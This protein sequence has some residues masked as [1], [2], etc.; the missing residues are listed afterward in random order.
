MLHV[1][2]S[3]R[4]LVRQTSYLDPF[5]QVPS[6]VVV[7]PDTEY[8]HFAISRHASVLAV[9]SFAPHISLLT[10]QFPA[11][12]TVSEAADVGSDTGPGL[13]PRGSRCSLTV[14]ETECPFLGGGELGNCCSQVSQPLL[15]S[16]AVTM[17]QCNILFPVRHWDLVSDHCSVQQCFSKLSI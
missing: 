3:S 10:S 1:D 17:P 7:H 15:Q 9:L 2:P 16:T 13:R 6:C 8:G 14:Y 12:A 4:T 11:A 5:R